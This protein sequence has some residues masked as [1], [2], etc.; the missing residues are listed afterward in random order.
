MSPASCLVV[1]PP[2]FPSLACRDFPR[3]PLAGRQRTRVCSSLANRTTSG[4]QTR[5]TTSGDVV[6][7]TPNGNNN[8]KHQQ[9]QQQ[10]DVPRINNKNNNDDGGPKT[11]RGDR[12]SGV[13]SHGSVVVAV[14]L[15]PPGVQHASS[16]AVHGVHF[17]VGQLGDAAA[18]SAVLAGGC[19]SYGDVVSVLE[20]TF[21]WFLVVAGA[22]GAPIKLM[23]DDAE[24]SSVVKPYG[25]TIL[26][27]F[28]FLLIS[29]KSLLMFSS[30]RVVSRRF[31][32]TRATNDV[33]VVCFSGYS[34]IL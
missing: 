20:R 21:S 5:Y 9:Q 15:L 27:G 2:P 31:I 4:G 34:T 11:D 7:T 3:S 17:G 26:L 8:N 6:N 33:F 19:F 28:F 14:R 22:A 32:V 30:V 24:R 25:T 1:P 16:G 23:D 29:F 13:C 10:R 18:R 12:A